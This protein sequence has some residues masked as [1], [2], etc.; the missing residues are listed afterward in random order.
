MSHDHTSCA[1]CTSKRTTSLR[2]FFEPT[3]ATIRPKYDD[4]R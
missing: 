2:R 3:K 1:M 4:R